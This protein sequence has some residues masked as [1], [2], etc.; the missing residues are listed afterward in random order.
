MGHKR[1]L[2]T[3]TLAFLYHLL[4]LLYVLLANESDD[5]VDDDDRA[6]LRF[7]CQWKQKSIV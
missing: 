2:S 6:I 7:L 1:L 3:I 5:D 4:A